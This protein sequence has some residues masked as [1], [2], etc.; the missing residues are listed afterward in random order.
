[1][2][3]I[4]NRLRTL[5]GYLWPYAQSYR[6]EI[7]GCDKQIAEADETLA[8]VTNNSQEGDV[9]RAFMQQCK[10][11]GWKK[12]LPNSVGD[13]LDI[14]GQDITECNAI[15]DNIK[16]YKQTKISDPLKN[17]QKKIKKLDRRL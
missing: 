9:F 11:I 10:E 14:I 3:R 4:K 12:S 2:A 8:N 1:M 13:E 17:A 16:I 7:D 15:I 6:T 5:N